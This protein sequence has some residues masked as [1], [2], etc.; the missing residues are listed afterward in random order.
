MRFINPANFARLTSGV[1]LAMSAAGGVLLVAG[2]FW[3]KTL[4]RIEF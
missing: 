1:G 2:W 4:N 3:M